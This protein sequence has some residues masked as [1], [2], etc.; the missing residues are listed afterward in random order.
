MPTLDL[1]QITDK[2]NAEFAKASSDALGTR[3]IVF[4]YDDDADFEDDIEILGI[5]GAKLHKLTL[6]NQFS[7]KYLLEREDTESSYLI[8]AP[9]TK[10]DVRDNALEDILLYSRRFYADRASLVTV[11]L[12]ISEKYKPILQKHVRFFT[13]KYRTR[14]FYNFEIENFT[15]ETIEIALMSA[16]CKTQTASF[17]EVLRVVLMDSCQLSVTSSQEMRCDFSPSALVSS[18]FLSEFEKYDLLQ[19]FWRI[20]EESLG[21]TDADPSL[22][23]LT[24]TLFVTYAS[25]QLVGDMPE[26]WTS[27]VSYKAGN[28]VAFMDNLM[29]SI[30]YS[31]QFNR[32]EKY[33]SSVLNVCENLSGADIDNILECDAFAVVD[34]FIVHWIIERL[35]NEDIGATAGGMNIPAISNLRMKKHFGRWYERYYTMLITAYEIIN[36]AHYNCLE[37]FESI[38]KQYI[39]SDYKLDGNYRSFYTAYDSYHSFVVN[40]QGDS[41]SPIYK[42]SERLIEHL[43]VRVENIYTNK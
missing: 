31:T 3:K 29:N 40:N 9:F 5:V 17:E 8:Y 33:I 23:R 27:F 20:C 10:P 12:N 39:K 13:D 11:D 18:C 30:L 7:T 41:C 14:R 37:Q 42:K 1:R 21:Y 43:R 22:L 4:W 16:L 19:A 25:R 24:T 36:K 35:L 32:L 26:L 38:V 6:T 28:I 15:K 34:E 2:L